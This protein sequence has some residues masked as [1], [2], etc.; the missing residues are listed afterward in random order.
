MDSMIKGLF[1]GDDDNDDRRSRA[2]DFISRYE[3]GPIDQGYDE[4]EAYEQF[5]RVSQHAD[6]DTIHR[7]SEQAFSRMDPMQRQQFAQYLQQQGGGQFSGGMSDDPRQMAGMVSQ[8]H[9]QNPSGLAG[10]FGGGGSGGGGGIGDALGGLLG[11][12]SGGGGGFPGGSLGKVAMGGIAAYAMKELMGG[13]GNDNDNNNRG[14]R[15]SV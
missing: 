13:G 5:Q 11:G 7:A 9:R 1:G 12:G 8:M 3:Q 14:R 15:R 6:P 10:L 4:N 2:S